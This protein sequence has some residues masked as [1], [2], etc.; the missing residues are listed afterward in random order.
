MCKKILAGLIIFISAMVMCAVSAS[1]ETYKDFDYSVNGDGTCK[2]TG[3]TGTGSKITIPSEIDGKT[4]TAISY[5]TFKEKK[6]IVSVTIPKTVK[7]IG[8]DAFNGC[9]NLK[10]VTMK[11]GVETIGYYAFQGCTKLSEV[12]I[13]S[14]VTLIKDD[15]FDNTKIVNDQT[16][17]LIY[18]G[19]WLVGASGSVSGSIKIK[20]GTV[21]IANSVFTGRELDSVTFPDSLKYIGGYAFSGTGLKSLTLPEGLK[22]IG[23]SA[24]SLCCG[25]TSVT[26]PKSVESI[27]DDAF[28]ACSKLEKVTLPSGVKSV[29][30]GAFSGTPIINNAPGDVV[31]I[32]KWLIMR[33]N[34]DITSVKI[35][36]GTVGIANSAFSNCSDLQKVTIPSSV[37]YINAYAF[38]SCRSL[39]SVSVPKGAQVAENAFPSTVSI[40]V[41]K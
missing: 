30:A 29:G 34:K 19:Q 5:E 2:I 33:K 13:P 7:T 23:D 40:K 17:D 31:Y 1:A 18:I 39:K 41:S 37:T 27:G 26:I 4:V 28:S 25:I 12:T 8:S 6:T 16:G 24:F 22:T 10:T 14:S 35:K 3:Y 15:A 20:S 21:G 36:D 11:K 38:S 32:G 9:T